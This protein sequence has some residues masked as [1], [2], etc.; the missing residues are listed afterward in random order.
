MGA[1]GHQQQGRPQAFLFSSNSKVERHRVLCLRHRQIIKR[2]DD[3]DIGI[4]LRPYQQGLQQDMIFDHIAHG[5]QSVLGRIE[6][7]NPKMPG[8]GDMDT[9]DCRGLR[10]Q[11]PPQIQRL[12]NLGTGIG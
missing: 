2:R 10:L 7:G 4:A 6:P 3:N 8:T 11:I 1:I 9:L 12:Q 5:A